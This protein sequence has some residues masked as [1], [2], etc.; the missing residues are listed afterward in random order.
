MEKNNGGKC[1][2]VVSSC[3]NY[4]DTWQPFFT[5]LKH[6]WSDIT[7]PIVL[8]TETKSFSIAGLNITSFHL[9]SKANEVPWSLRLKE[10]LK[11]IDTPYIIFFL[12]DFFLESKVDNL[13]IEQC[14]QWMDKDPSITCFDFYTTIYGKKPCQYPGFAQRKRFSQYKFNAQ[15]CLWRRKDLISYL[16]DD[17]DPW[18]W[19]FIGNLRSFRTSKK[20]Y[21]CEDNVKPV[22][23]YQLPGIVRGKWNPEIVEPIVRKYGIQLDYSKRPKATHEEVV[24]HTNALKETDKLFGLRVFHGYCVNIIRHFKSLF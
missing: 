18:I 8:N 6:N 3:D 5:V 17:E 15:A 4:E 11:R 16:R 7:F 9:F 1:T 20:F 24:D 14:I 22:F 19:E 2:V 13:K 21:C 23:D 12:E 10:T